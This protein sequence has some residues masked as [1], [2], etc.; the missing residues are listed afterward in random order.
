MT[1]PGAVMVGLSIGSG[2]LVLWP[3]ITARFGEVMVWAAAFGV[4]IQVWINIEIGRWVIAT[5]ESVFIGFTRVARWSVYYFLML[6][7]LIA[8]VP[9]WA[10]ASG[11]SVKL[12]IFGPDGPGADWMWTAFAFV[13]VWAILF[14]PKYVYRALEISVII[15]VLIITIGMLFVAFTVGTFS[16]ALTFSSGLLKIGHIELTEDFTG[17]KLFGA[18]V[19]AGAGGFGNLFYAYYLREK[20]IGMGQRMPAMVSALRQK[21]ASG[22]EAGFKYR[23]TPANASHFRDWLRYVV[24]DNTLY[25]WLL[26]TFTMLLFMYGAFVVLH[27]RGQVPA[28]STIIWDLAVILESSLGVWGRYL[29]L[30]IA[31]AA[32]FSTQLTF[33]D[34]TARVWTDLFH[35]NF[36]FAR[37]W[38]ANQWYLFFVVT[39]SLLGIA[40][41]WFSENNA[42]ALD[43]FFLNAAGNGFAMAVYTP[44]LIYLNIKDLPASARPHPL[45][46]LMMLI[47]SATYL[48]FAVYVI[49]DKLF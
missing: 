33:S 27:A 48:S 5:G 40:A 4:F 29:Y 20:G 17:A 32:L 38:A 36:K 7:L 2:E 15:M 24:L 30:V 46:V 6:L 14:G 13:C 11:T 9:G 35:L 49:Y 28:E 45:N 8:I 26:N 47:A 3:W 44:L 22:A 16:D 39:L 12:L 43:F 41:T 21:Q 1:G 37:R 18:V 19:F 34:G 25:F 10:R 42:S 31:V 23:D